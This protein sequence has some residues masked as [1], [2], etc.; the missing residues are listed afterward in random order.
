[1]SEGPPKR[2]N[3]SPFRVGG[4]A[5]LHA[6]MPADLRESMSKYMDVDATYEIV[7]I[8]RHDDEG[9][10][11]AYIRPVGSNEEPTPIALE[12]LSPLLH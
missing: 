12:H 11:A 10:D 4:H 2:G 1:M 5:R 8:V 9:G 3:E 7:E 6:D